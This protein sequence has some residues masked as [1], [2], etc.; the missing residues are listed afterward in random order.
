LAVLQLSGNFHEVVPGELYR[1]AQPSPE[2]LAAYQREFGI[3][4]I[5]NLRG[6]KQ[7][8]G[9]YE[10]EVAAAR[11]LGIMHVDYRMSSSSELTQ[12]RAAELLAILKDAEKPILVHC[13]SGA[14]R[15][16]LVSALYVAQI[17]QQGE[18]AAEGQISVLYGHIPI[19]LLSAA[20]AMDSTWEKL[21]AWLGYEHS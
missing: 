17:A 10:S 11:R 4:T 19:P 18:E 7:G 14:D 13:Q 2:R 12:Q 9:W 20:F 8:R 16:G 5:I 15:S 1:S 6:A 3:K 21:E